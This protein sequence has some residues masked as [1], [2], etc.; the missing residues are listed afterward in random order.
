M[1][2]LPTC[3]KIPTFFNFNSRFVFCSPFLPTS[4]VSTSVPPEPRDLWRPSGQRTP[5]SPGA[6][7]FAPGCCQR[8]G[9]AGA[10]MGRDRSGPG[11]N[12]AGE[13]WLRNV[14]AKPAKIVVMWFKESQ[15]PAIWKW[16]I[17][18]Y[19]I[20]GDLGDGLLLF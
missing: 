1:S 18:V 14:V 8:R 19:T 6:A 2:L 3:A 12:V 15:K 7:A 10:R 20:Y 9:S 16:F 13:T 11:R 4:H 5:R 17:H